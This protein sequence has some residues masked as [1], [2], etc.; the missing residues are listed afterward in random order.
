MINE[1]NI[2]VGDGSETAKAQV[3]FE[4]EEFFT[5]KVRRGERRMGLGYG[6]I[7]N[8]AFPAVGA[9]SVS[10]AATGGVVLAICRI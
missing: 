1:T 9:K 8:N 2:K 5:R 6:P 4:A 3:M 7:A 10:D